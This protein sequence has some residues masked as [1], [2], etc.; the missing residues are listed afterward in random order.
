M[1]TKTKKKHRGI[2]GNDPG[3]LDQAQLTD[4]L[5]HRLRLDDPLDPPLD[6]RFRMEAPEELFINAWQQYAQTGFRNRL[7]RAIRNNLKRVIQLTAGRGLDSSDNEQIAS[8]AFLADTITAGRP[9]WPV[10]R[11]RWNPAPGLR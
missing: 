7:V 9:D 11:C 1:S 8:L 10:V 6:R 4:L 3:L 5:W 2:T